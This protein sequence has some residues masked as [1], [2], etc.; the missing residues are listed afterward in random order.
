MPFGDGGT[1]RVQGKHAQRVPVISR[2]QDEDS[3]GD[4]DE[5]N[6][7][8]DDDDDEEDDEEEDDQEPV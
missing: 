4:E 3:E 8:Y 7:D 5:D 6:E 1:G 2:I